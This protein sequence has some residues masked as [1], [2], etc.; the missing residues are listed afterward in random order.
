[1]LSQ[2]PAIAFIAEPSI[3]LAAILL[4]ISGS[5]Y[6]FNQGIDPLILH[7]TGPEYRGR[8]FTVQT[9]GLMAIQGVSIAL[10][11]AIGTVLRPNLTIC[12]AGLVGTAVTLLLARRALV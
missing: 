5:G 9:S 11:G 2:T 7:A 12:L 3:A 4:A 10:A 6:A 1:L 8:L